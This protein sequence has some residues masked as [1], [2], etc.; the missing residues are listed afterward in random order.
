[1]AKTGFER[2]SDS[3]KTLLIDSEGGHDRLIDSEG[4][5]YNHSTKEL[6]EHSSSFN[7]DDIA[8]SA[9]LSMFLLLNAM[10]GSGIL[11][12]PYVFS[13]SGV[14]GG[15]LAFIVA[16]FFTW[17]GLMLLTE[18]GVAR[19]VLEYSGLTKRVFGKVGEQVVDFFI[20]IQAFGSQLGYILVVGQTSTEL[21]NGWGCN[22]V[23]CGQYATT[24]GT[25]ILFVTPVCLL[26]HFGHLAILSLFSILAIVLCIAL[27]VIGG[28]VTTKNDEKSDVV[29]FDVIGMLGSAGS[30]VFALS[31]APANF[32]A[33][34]STEKKSQN[35]SV[36]TWVTGGAV[37]LGAIMCMIM[38]ICKS[39]INLTFFKK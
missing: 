20:V 3:L 22:N 36:W 25:T 18:T 13:Q 31:C 24:I 12:Q 2:D 6:S 29:V 32:Q 4:N 14:L 10:I 5:A 11:N 37:I 27:V 17:G 9:Y 1:M 7:V 8:N 28:P 23:V 34:I 16:A 39:T 15:I 33:Y 26:R 35:V 30:I 19:G 38:G 21:L